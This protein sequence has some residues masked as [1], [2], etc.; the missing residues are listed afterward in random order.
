MRISDWSS[1]VCSSDLFDHR[2]RLNAAAFHYD[3]KNYQFQ[4]LLQGAAF[5]FNGP[6]AKLTGGE[7]EL[8]VRPA[9]GLTL[10]ANG[11]YLH[12]RIADSPGAPN[13]CQTAIGVPDQ[14]GFF[15]DPVT[16]FSTTTPYNAKV[17]RIPT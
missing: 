12:S 3:F 4:K 14:G 6:S 1:D 11:A 16:G 17:N 7:I 5:I 2:V 9:R 13:T 10:T 8:E 15:C